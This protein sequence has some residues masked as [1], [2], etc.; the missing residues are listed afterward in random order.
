M[1]E[2]LISD[3]FIGAAILGGVS[4]LTYLGHLACDYMWLRDIKKRAEN[5]NV[6]DISL[7]SIMITCDVI[8]NA[9]LI[10]SAILYVSGS[11]L[12]DKNVSHGLVM[13]SALYSWTDI[14]MFWM[15]KIALIGHDLHNAVAIEIQDIQL[16]NGLAPAG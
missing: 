6:S 1:R 7:S 5:G 14:K 4:T 9:L 16:E 13:G 15:S 11:N 8:P 12:V 2:F 3:K 10:A